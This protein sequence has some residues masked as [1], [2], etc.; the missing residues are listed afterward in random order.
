MSPQL[1][2]H[3]S[4]PTLNKDSVLPILLVELEEIE[5]QLEMLQQSRARLL[6]QIAQ[7]KQQVNRAERLLQ[8]PCVACV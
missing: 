8:T 3:Q 5:E 1:I 6:N 2:R 4:S 7:T